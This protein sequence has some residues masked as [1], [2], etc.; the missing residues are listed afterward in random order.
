MNYEDKADDSI[1]ADDDEVKM[2]ELLLVNAVAPQNQASGGSE[3]SD[4]WSAVKPQLNLVPF[5]WTT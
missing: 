1:K 2:A 3:V 4:Q 5:I